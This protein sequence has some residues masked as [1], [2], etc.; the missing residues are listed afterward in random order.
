MRRERLAHAVD[1]LAVRFGDHA[2]VPATLLRR[3]S[4]PP[5]A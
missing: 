3:P 4:R 2:V 5:R 1:R